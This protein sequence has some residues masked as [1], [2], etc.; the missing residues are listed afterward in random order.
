MTT[1]TTISWVDPTT[2]EDGSP[3]VAGEITGYVIGIRAGVVGDGGAGG[4]T[5][6]AI[7]VGPAAVSE[8]L[9]ALGTVVTVPGNYVVAVQT[10]GPTNSLWSAEVPLVIAAPPPPPKPVPAAPTSVKI[11]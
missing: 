3:I 1:L 7:A 11:S 4:Y 9:S 5:T 2:N 6:K 10:N 8:A